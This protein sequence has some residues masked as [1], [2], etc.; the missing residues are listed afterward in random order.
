MAYPTEG[1][2]GGD[3]TMTLVFASSHDRGGPHP[4][5]N[6]DRS[7]MESTVAMANYDVT[8]NGNQA[9]PGQMPSVLVGGTENVLVVMGTAV[10]QST[11]LSQIVLSGCTTNI[12]DEA[13][14]AGQLTVKFTATQNMGPGGPVN[15]TIELTLSDSTSPLGPYDVQLVVTVE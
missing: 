8:I 12:T 6:R 9:G 5:A 7:D 14:Q 1:A 13:A 10:T 11:S 3:A 2:D 15:D 4:D